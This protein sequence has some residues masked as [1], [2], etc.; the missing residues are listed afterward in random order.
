MAETAVPKEA[1]AAITVLLQDLRREVLASDDVPIEV[2]AFMLDT[3]IDL[4]RALDAYRLDG[5]RAFQDFVDRVYGR[6]SRAGWADP[7]TPCH[8]LIERTR[9]LVRGIER[10]TAAYVVAMTLG[11]APAPAALWG[12]VKARTR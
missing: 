2:R 7:D 12:P 5:I 8:P 6:Y 9:W 11:W 4:E 3:L 10:L 1:L